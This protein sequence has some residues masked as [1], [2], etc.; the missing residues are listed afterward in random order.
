MNLGTLGFLSQFSKNDFDKALKETFH[1]NDSEIFDMKVLN[2][3]KVEVEVYS[4]NSNNL[5]F[6]NKR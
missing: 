4:P 2:I 6:S 5:L 1:I 3:P